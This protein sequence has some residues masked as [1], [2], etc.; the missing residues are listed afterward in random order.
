MNLPSPLNDWAKTHNGLPGISVRQHLLTVSCV[1][2]E[3]LRRYPLFCTQCRI[4]PQDVLFLAASHDVG[5]LS[6]DFLQQSP[7]WLERQGLVAAAQQG[8]WKNV[9]TRSHAQVSHDSLYN[10][11]CAGRTDKRKSAAC[12]AA[13]AGAHHGGLVRPFTTRP[14]LFST[15]E[16]VLEEERQACL[17][18]FWQRY[19]SPRLPDVERNDDPALWCVAGLITLADWIGSDESFFPP[20][21]SLAEPQIR[22]CAAQA[23]TAI[24]L[25][26][27]TVRQGLNFHEIFSGREPYPL[28]TCA[29]QT[30]T[31]PGVYV[32]EAPMGMGKTEAALWAAY[33]LL[34]A[35]KASGLFFALPTQATSNR[36]F[37]RLAA[38][39]RCICP[40]AAPVQLVHSSAWL[41]TDLKALASQDGAG[42]TDPCWF[43]TARRAL[44]APFGVG[45]VDQALMSVL[46]VR[47]F[48]LRR[49]ALAGKV[50]IVDEVHTYDM[51]TGT[52]VR[53]LCRELA[54]LGC[55]VVILSATLTE[56]ARRALLSLPAGE[57]RP[58]APYPRIS[59]CS[60]AGQPSEP[61][62]AGPRSASVVL[63]EI[64]PPSLPD[65]TVRIEHPDREAALAQAL[66]LASD[67]AQVLW[68]CDTIGRAQQDFA[69]LHQ[70]AASLAAT[71]EV[72]LLHARF[73]FFRREALERAWLERFGPDGHRQAGAILVS[74]Q[75]VEQSVD[76]DADAL[77][78]ELAPTDML[79]QRLGRLWRHPRAG[80]PLDQPLFCLL[81]EADACQTFKQLDA[82]AIT[83]RLGAKACVYN[84]YAL[85][86]SLEVW[87]PLACVHLP[88]A[89][90]GL[91]AATYAEQD[92]PPGW[93]ELY[94][95]RYGNDLADRRLADMNTDIWQLALDDDASLHTRLSGEATALLVLCTASKGNRLSLLEGSEVVLADTAVPSLDVAKKLHRN[96]VRI[97]LSCLAS[98]P[99]DNR[100]TPYHI[101]SYLL[102]HGHDITLPQ[103]KPGRRLQWD[104]A[105]G[106]IICKE[107]R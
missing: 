48:P 42:G 44:F 98:I 50:V 27:P 28:Q 99:S 9:Y 87:E 51:Y 96:T 37:L 90:R 84:P 57:E 36:M 106:V 88:S 55:T 19:G 39:V 21:Q 75:I 68:I 94:A 76:L 86:R 46:A 18:E 101:N 11:L 24:G 7:V 63:P 52:L 85:L 6:L 16:R 54:Q 60:S 83:A 82:A 100:L 104:D 65:K 40:T 2:E 62:A 45:T 77:F 15:S 74:T 56:T 95:A 29:A 43:N 49:F 31:G 91:M 58:D 73:P 71:P 32:I 20:D 92:V 72:G 105:L 4:T 38:F 64:C 53:H 47:H 41:Q 81:R 34:T 3:L 26:L 33:H 35:G 23:V 70:R 30:I 107:E 66:T 14:R 78:S 59:G 5:K 93:D 61:A 103:I 97:P 1:A 17:L 102:V 67:G 89:I 79:L 80:R 10:F 12:W 13:V 25:G 22:Q 69:A 8:G